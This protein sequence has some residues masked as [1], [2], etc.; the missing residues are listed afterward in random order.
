VRVLA[1]IVAPPHLGVSGAVR[2][3]LDLSVALADAHC[4]MDVALMADVDD[5]TTLGRARVIRQRTTNPLSFTRRFLPNRYRTLFYRAPIG[6]LIRQGRYDLVHIHNLMPTAQMRRVAEA[7]TAADIPYVVSTHGIVEAIG[8][9]AVY[10]LNAL[11]QRLAWRAFVDRPL[12]WVFPHAAGVLALSSSDIELV[13]SLGV[14]ESVVSVVPNAVSEGFVREIPGPEIDKVLVEVGLGD[15][16]EQGLPLC[17]FLANHANSKGIDVLLAAVDGLRSPIA[18]VVGGQRRDHLDYAR[19]ERSSRADHR[20][21]FPGALDLERLQALYA[22]ADLFV[23]PTLA[24]TFPLVVLEAMAYGC[25][26]ISTTVG[27]IPE[28]V[29]DAEAVLVP[30]GDVGQLREALETLLSD[31]DRRRHMS[32]A[33]RKAALRYIGWAGPAGLAYAAYGRAV[34][35]N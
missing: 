29:Q 30:P 3:G 5:E 7:A 14:P 18:L 9:P 35:S 28:Q 34:S 16:D 4:E 8:G 19:W 26:I 23:L 25:P 24:D 27:G 15:L 31:P 33:S 20:I 11:P 21:I 6:R 12:R 22:R 10:S 13:A 1:A 2:A 17:F 32:E